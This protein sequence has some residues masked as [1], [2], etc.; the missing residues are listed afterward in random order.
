MTPIVY[1]SSVALAQLRSNNPAFAPALI[2]KGNSR[3]PALYLG[4]V[5]ISTI[6]DH[7]LCE[8]LST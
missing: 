7:R 2:W 6:S 3:T 8:V 5:V 4:P 1:Y